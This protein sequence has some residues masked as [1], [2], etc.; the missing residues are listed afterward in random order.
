MNIKIEWN[1]L[2]DILKIRLDESLVFL[3]GSFC[4]SKKYML[5]L[6]GYIRAYIVLKIAPTHGN[7]KKM[8]FFS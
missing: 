5:L 7:N 6:G 8:V 2:S 4:R 3:F 1:S